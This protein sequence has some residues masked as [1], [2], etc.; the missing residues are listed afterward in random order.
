MT[1]KTKRLVVIGS[2]LAAIIVVEQSALLSLSYS[3]SDSYTRYSGRTNL[4]G[5]D[6]SRVVAVDY[7]VTRWLPLVKFGETVIT[8]KY[9]ASNNCHQ[10]LLE[11]SSRA[12][13][14]VFGFM[15]TR[16]YEDLARRDFE[17]QSRK[18]EQT[19]RR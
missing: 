12:D 5:V 18:R 1:P 13:V 3:R 7:P 14:W 17:A 2:I 6:F 11:T 9:T 4:A 8:E 10:I 16:K 15:S 19:A